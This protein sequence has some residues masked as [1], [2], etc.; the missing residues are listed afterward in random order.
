MLPQRF[1]RAFIWRCRAGQLTLLSGEAARGVLGRT[2]D[3]RA[4]AQAAEVLRAKT[5]PTEQ[6]RGSS[7]A[8][9][10]Q[11]WGPAVFLGVGSGGS[12]GGTNGLTVLLLS[13]SKS[14]SSVTGTEKMER[15]GQTAGVGR[16]RMLCCT[17]CAA[18]LH[19][20]CA[21]GVVCP[22]SVS[23]KQIQLP[24]EGKS[25]G[26]RMK[27]KPHIGLLWVKSHQKFSANLC[28]C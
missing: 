1:L 15:F 7:A 12:A 9:R 8:W 21:P 26:D 4:A 23:N 24:A 17:A 14:L 19:C 2:N 6:V 5:D 11:R 18:R 22:A 28:S 27:G 25:G 16:M 20:L 13:Q 10:L 3:A